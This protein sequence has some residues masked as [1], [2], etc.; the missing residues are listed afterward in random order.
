MLANDPHRAIA[1]PSLR[2]IVHLAAPGWNV[3]GGGEPTLPG[4]SIGHNDD[5]AWGL[6]IFETDAEDMY[7][8]KLNPK[9][10]LQ[11]FYKGQWKQL[12]KSVNHC[13]KK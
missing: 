3:V 10:P 13:C 4:V 5:G 8:Y 11:Y 6:T 9:N 1:T 12:K 7:V 2:Y